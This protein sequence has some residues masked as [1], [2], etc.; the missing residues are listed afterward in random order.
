MRILIVML[1]TVIVSLCVGGT[2]SVAVAVQER[3]IRDRAAEQVYDVASS[4]ARLEQ[5]RAVLQGSG[6]VGVAASGDVSDPG[7][8]ASEVLIAELQEVADLTERAAGVDYVVV[9][10][11]EGVRLTHP[12]EARRGEHVSTDHSAVLQG[13]EFVGTEVG[14][15]GPTL[16]AKVPVRGEDGVVGVVSVGVLEAKIAEDLN[17]A[18]VQM[19]PWAAVALVVGTVLSS[20]LGAAL[21]RRLRRLEAVAAESEQQQRTAAILREQTHE[22]HTRMHVVHGLVSQGEFTQALDY[23]AQVVPLHT[24]FPGDSGAITDASKPVSVLPAVHPLLRAVVESL[25]AELR[26]RRVTLHADVGA[27]IVPDDQLVVVVSNLCI[28]ASESGARSV[29]LTL[30]SRDG[31]V[32]GVVEDDGPGIPQKLARKVFSRGYSSKPDVGGLGRGVGLDLVLQ[33]VTSRR[34][35]IEIG[36]SRASGAR[37][38]FEWPE[39]ALC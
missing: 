36:A 28:N 39:E 5:V 12:D 9:A 4:V 29:W 20:L 31:M 35:S 8:I 38:S 7:R 6:L 15:L 14:T 37:F 3:S 22:F 18:L 10:D 11:I 21:N 27:G 30:E 24:A 23:I 17:E 16:R 34:G 1:P 32:R 19:V 26:A 33:A 13:R 2:L 25:T